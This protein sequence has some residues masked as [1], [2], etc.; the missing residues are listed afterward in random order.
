MKLKAQLIDVDLDSFILHNYDASK[1]ELLPSS[2][3]RLTSADTSITG[4][5]IRTTQ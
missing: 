1:L 4:H 2:I 3:I 5:I